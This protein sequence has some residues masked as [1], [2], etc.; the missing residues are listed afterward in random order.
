MSPAN[1]SEIDSARI[2]DD[3]D[4]YFDGGD[5]LNGSLYLCVARGTAKPDAALAALR[6]AG[7]WSGETEKQVADDQREAYKA[8]LKFVAAVR[9][10]AGAEDLLLA[11]FDHPKFPSDPARWAAWLATFDAG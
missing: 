4:L 8:G 1:S 10:R 11:R 9:C 2:V 6:N 3:Y 5:P 7:L